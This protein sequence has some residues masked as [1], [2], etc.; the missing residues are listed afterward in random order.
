MAPYSGAPRPPS[1][2]VV[3]SLPWTATLT[4]AMPG[5]SSFVGISGAYALPSTD[6][7]D[8]GGVVTGTIL[9]DSFDAHTLFD[10]GASFSFVSDAFVAHA[11]LFRQKVSQSIVVNSTKG[12]ISSTLVCPGCSI[13]LADDTFVANHVVIPF[14]SFDVILGMD[15]LSQYY[16]VISCFWKAVS[17]HALSGREVIFVGSAL[18]YSLSL[19]Y[20]LFLNHWER[21]SG[22]IFAMMDNGEAPF[23]RVEDI[24]VVCHY[25]DVF[26]SKLLDIPPTQGA[27]F[28]IK[29]IPG[30]MPIHNNPYQMAPK[31]QLELK[32]QLEDLIAKGFTRP[33]KSPWAFH[34]LFVEKKDGSKRLCVYYRALNAVTMKNKYPL[35]RID[36]LFEELRGAKIFSKIDLNSYY[37]QL[38]IR[39]GDI[40]KTA[41]STRYRHYEYIVMS[42]GLTNA[43]VA[44]MEAMNRMLHEYLDDF[45]IVFFDNILINSKSEEE[46]ERH[47]S[48][49]LEALQKN[50]FYAKLKKYAFW[51]FLGHVINQHG[52]SV[53]PKNVSI[54]VKW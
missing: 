15:W 36:V 42:F 48:L 32:K 50:Q 38:R 31:E 46:H 44:F 18:K 19:L 34:V 7:R 16:A 10:S 13:F 14:E 49:V 39:E 41:F 22:I 28:E 2:P 6:G 52:I 23:L 17:L 47:L 54:V 5:G 35:P 29:L 30:T 3:S 12:L 24:C 4:N 20:Q 27:S 43:P 33:S 40:E 45:V 21:K 8:H 9:F 1:G 53:Y 51:S 37:H 26:P 11:R 25:L